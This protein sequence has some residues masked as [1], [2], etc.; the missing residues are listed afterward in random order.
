MGW[1]EKALGR[2]EHRGINQIICGIK[3]FRRANALRSYSLAHVI[4][5]HERGAA[6]REIALTKEGR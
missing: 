6:A 3:N 1:R 4:A 2:P 5:I